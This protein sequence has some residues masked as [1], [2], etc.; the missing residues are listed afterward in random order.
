MMAAYHFLWMDAGLKISGSAHCMHVGACSAICYLGMHPDI[1][2]AHI[3]R[4]E[5]STVCRIHYRLSL[6]LLP[7]DFLF[8]LDALTYD[9]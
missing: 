1:V 4:H 2:H 5:D 9:I 6:V 8:F 3:R 7:F